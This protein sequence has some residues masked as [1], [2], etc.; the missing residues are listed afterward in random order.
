M[1][2]NNNYN[3]KKEISI[4]K[5]KSRIL[6]PLLVS[7][8]ILA[9]PVF[10]SE[11]NLRF[12]HFWPVT[13]GIAAELDLWAQ[14]IEEASNG[15]ISVDVYAAETL[16]RSTQTYESVQRGIVDVGATIQGYTA[17][18]FP[19]S[20]IVELPGIVQSG[21]QGSC[22]LQSLYDEGYLDNEYRD[23]HPLFMFTHGPGHI[24]TKGRS[25]TKPSDLSGMLVRRPT[26]V[27]GELLRGLGG[28]PVGLAAPE[29][30][31]AMSRGVINGVT[32][33]WEAMASFRLN[34]LVDHHT[35]IG[36]YSLALIVT[37]NKRAYDTMPADL[38][39]IIDYHSGMRWAT[40]MGEAYDRLDAVGIEQAQ[41]LG[42]TI[43]VIDNV[44][45]HPEWKPILDQVSSS[46]LS[47][48]EGRG[49]S[50]QQVYDRALELA[51]GCS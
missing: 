39:D 10:A 40:R 30:Y 28:E 50:S 31:S 45:E 15:R 22:V 21:R 7:T 24:H 5:F 42:H 48:L 1:S 34:E 14:T 6:T 46:Y 26:V 32:L 38:R 23:T 17:N 47:E 44:S 33:P 8:C 37:M 25:V 2:A 3:D 12:A 36:L 27:V 13:S 43:T 35:Q 29:M 4:M 49:M 9:T 11:V 19:M 18:R 20:Q 16:T 41:A 51:T